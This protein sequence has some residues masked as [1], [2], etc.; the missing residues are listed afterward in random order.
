[1]SESNETAIEKLRKLRRLAIDQQDT[2]EGKLARSSL[3]KRLASMGLEE[4]DLDVVWKSTIERAS[5]GIFER[6]MDLL[7]ALALF[8]GLQT[9]AA[10]DGAGEV[11]GSDEEATA[12][13]KAYWAIRSR[14]ESLAMSPKL[15]AEAR[16]LDAEI[17][18][19]GSC[20]VSATIGVVNR[21]L[22]SFAD[23]EPDEPDEAPPQEDVEPPALEKPSEAP[24][25]S[26]A[27]QQALDRETRGITMI[28]QAYQIGYDLARAV[29]SRELTSRTDTKAITGDGA[30]PRHTS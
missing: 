11:G 7:T 12:C 4:R 26:D 21:A 15:A 22:E 17:D 23:N 2:P 28:Q 3:E 10:E 25:G 16:R 14:V 13:L 9:R 1:M 19:W 27:A 8:G 5:G 24:V 20:Y 6:R 18:W 30:K 29:V